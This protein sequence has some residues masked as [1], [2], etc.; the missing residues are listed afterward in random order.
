MANP[1][2]KPKRVNSFDQNESASKS[3]DNYNESSSMQL[4][5]IILG[6]KNVELAAELLKEDGTTLNIVDFACS[7][8]KNSM[9]VIN[10]LFDHLNTNN[11]L[12]AKNLKEIIVYHNDLPDNDFDE[13]LKCV[14]DKEIG[15]KVN[16]LIES[17][18]IEIETRFVGKTY[19]EQIVEN[20]SI[21]F[22]FCYTSLHWMPEYCNLNY[23]VMYE[24]ERENSEMLKWITEMSDRYLFKWLE[25]RH[26][27]LKPS[28]LL[29]FNI[30][31]LSS[32]PAI[33]NK[34]WASL[35]KSKNIDPV[36]L[37]SVTIPVLVR[38][39]EQIDRL[40]EFIKDKFS[41]VNN[42]FIKDTIEMDKPT[43]RAVCY[44]QITTGLYKHPNL[45]PDMDSI[46]AF[47][48]EFE[49][50]IYSLGETVTLNSGFE[51]ILL[52]KI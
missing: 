39:K 17:N 10:Q 28:G 2:Y 49:Q 51:W 36:E 7:H 44:N 16:E 34:A 13:V 29:S 25:L 40:F 27:E 1:N 26:Q 23:S 45:F 52:Q 8:G 18:N 6:R 37:S 14:E 43:L 50:E 38:T 30:C 46:E 12:L 20:E 42:Q 47:Y 22:A 48:E 5:W 31:T 32:F 41:L 21:N 35:L 19:Y 11:V 4:N 9:T 24:K 3:M 15:Y 33:V